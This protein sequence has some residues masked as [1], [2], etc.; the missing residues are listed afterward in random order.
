MIPGEFVDEDDRNS[1]PGLFVEQLDAIVGCQVRHWR[2]PGE[3][4]ISDNVLGAIIRRRRDLHDLEIV[5][6]FDVLLRDFALI[7]NAVA[8]AHHHLAEPLELGAEP[9]AHHEDQMKAGVVIVPLGSAA[10]LELLDG[11]TDGPAD[12]AFGGFRQAEIAIFQKRP[13][14]LARPVGAVEPRQD[15]FGLQ[16]GHGSSC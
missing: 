1:D 6:I 5:G 7:G 2:F 3:G 8:L 10:G 9:A 12:A 14:A 13:Q 11:P 4:Q 15:D 16:L